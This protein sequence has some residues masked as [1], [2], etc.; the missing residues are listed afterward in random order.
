MTLKPPR[1]IQPTKWDLFSKQKVGRRCNGR[2]MIEV[3]SSPKG[4]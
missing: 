2:I 1:V 3:F 4:H